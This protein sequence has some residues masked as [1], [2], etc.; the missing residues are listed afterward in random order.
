MNE[1]SSEEYVP[2]RR[3]TPKI[4][5]ARKKQKNAEVWPPQVKMIFLCDGGRLKLY[6]QK[7]NR[8][9]M[10]DLSHCPCIHAKTQDGKR[11]VDAQFAV[12]MRHVLNH[13]NMGSNVMSPM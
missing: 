1:T 6:Q 5:S 9:N 4:T 2:L 13:V 11:P 10:V 8:K 7:I 3:K 12:A